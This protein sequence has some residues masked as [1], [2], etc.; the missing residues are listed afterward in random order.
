MGHVVTS[1]PDL[2]RHLIDMPLVPSVERP[3]FWTDEWGIYFNPAFADQLTDL[4]IK[5]V[6]VHEILH[7]I[8]GHGRRRAKRDRVRW[9]WAA[10]YEVNGYIVRYMRERREAG[11]EPRLALP[12]GALVNPEFDAMTAEE[13]YEVLPRRRARSSMGQLIPARAP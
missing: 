5:G 10:D 11:Q 2:S 4:E 9:N 13:I 6:L 3:T 12:Q 1:L 8:W 7:A